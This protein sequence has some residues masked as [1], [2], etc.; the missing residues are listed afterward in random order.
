LYENSSDRNSI[1]TLLQADQGKEAGEERVFAPVLRVLRY[2]PQ[3]MNS[4]VDQATE[5][6][7][8]SFAFYLRNLKL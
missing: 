3:Q 6:D 8:G 5:E 2:P 1:E 7:E 4:K